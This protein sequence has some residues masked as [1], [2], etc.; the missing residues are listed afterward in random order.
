MIQKKFDRPLVA[1]PQAWAQPEW[2]AAWDPKYTI[3]QEN[4]PSL[5][6]D[7]VH[8]IVLKLK[9]KLVHF[10]PIGRYP[11]LFET[12]RIVEPQIHE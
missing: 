5:N 4:I 10:W 2:P 9:I 3:L 11:H 6:L 12:A 1:G 7:F 8:E